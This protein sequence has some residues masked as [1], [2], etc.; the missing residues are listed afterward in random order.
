LVDEA[1]TAKLDTGGAAKRRNAV[2]RKTVFQRVNRVAKGATRGGKLRELLLKLELN[3]RQHR[4]VQPVCVWA[5]RGISTPPLIS[6]GII[7]RF[8]EP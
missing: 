3:L 4:A 5:A 2:W 7:S 1:R 8:Q 6:L